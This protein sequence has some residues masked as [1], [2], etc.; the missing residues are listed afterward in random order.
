MY[1]RSFVESERP[2]WDQ[3]RSKLFMIPEAIPVRRNCSE[4]DPSVYRAYCAA[5]VY[6]LLDTLNRLSSSRQIRD[7]LTRPNVLNFGFRPGDMQ[8]KLRACG[9]Y[10]FKSSYDGCG[11]VLDSC[12][13]V[14]IIGIRKM[15]VGESDATLS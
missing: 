15:V 11:I 14:G 1:K 5:E 9:L 12:N 8:A 3:T 4:R 2:A 6:K 10:P 7:F 13:I